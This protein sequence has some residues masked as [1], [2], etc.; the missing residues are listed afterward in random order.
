MT[1]TD[2]MM[3]VVILLCVQCDYTG[4]QAECPSNAGLRRAVRTALQKQLARA[5]EPHAERYSVATLPRMAS[6]PS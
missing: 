4:T 3:A 5:C 6:L 1:T 2:T